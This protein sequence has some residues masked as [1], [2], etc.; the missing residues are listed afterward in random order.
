MIRIRWK[1]WLAARL[2]KRRIRK[3]NKLAGD[4]KD[5]LSPRHFPNYMIYR[6]RYR[7]YRCRDCRVI[8]AFTMSEGGEKVLIW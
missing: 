8:N 2:L 4:P 5:C 3:H 6:R 7:L 1:R